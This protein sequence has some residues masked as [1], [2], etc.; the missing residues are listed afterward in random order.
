MFLLDILQHPRRCPCPPLYQKRC[1]GSLARIPLTTFLYFFR[2]KL[3]DQNALSEEI[4]NAITGQSL[5]EP[6]DED[7]LESQ[8]E[9][10]QQEQLDEQM[11]KTGNVPVAD[12]VNKMP[13]PVI[14]ERMNAPTHFEARADANCYQRSQQRRMPWRTTKR[15]SWRNCGPRWPC[16]PVVCFSISALRQQHTSRGIGYLSGRDDIF[17]GMC[18][19]SGRTDAVTNV[20]QYLLFSLTFLLGSEAFGVFFLG[21]SFCLSCRLVSPALIYPPWPLSKVDSWRKSTGEP[22]LRGFDNMARGKCTRLSYAALA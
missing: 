19:A 13:S 22:Q 17:S 9:Q 2:D 5:G 20:F 8:L 14:T 4:V 18:G 21:V 16:R 3:R 7:D 10:L 15:Q 6:I 1:I 11:L 12:E